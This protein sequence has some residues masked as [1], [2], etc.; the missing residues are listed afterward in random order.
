MARGIH[1]HLHPTRIH[2]HTCT[3]RARTHAPTRAPLP[4]D[5]THEEFVA[6]FERPRLPVVL[7][8]LVEEWPAVRNWTPDALAANYGHHKFKVACVRC[9]A[10]ARVR[11]CL[12]GCMHGTLHACVRHATP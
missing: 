10:R 12:P 2:V 6:R 8:G 9:C 1:A 7:T 5:L 3:P 11:L 4:Q